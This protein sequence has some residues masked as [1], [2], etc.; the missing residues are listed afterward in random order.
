MAVCIPSSS[1]N[2][3]LR[4]AQTALTD[5][6][7]RV[8][9]LLSS[10]QGAV[11]SQHL[12]PYNCP[13]AHFPFPVNGRWS[14]LGSEQLPV[15]SGLQR[16]LSAEGSSEYATADC[17]SLGGM[18]IPSGSVP[19]G[20]MAGATAAAADATPESRRHILRDAFLQADLFICV[21]VPPKFSLDSHQ[22]FSSTRPGVLWH[23]EQ[24]EAA[25][26]S[27]FEGSDVWGRSLPRQS[28][29]D[30][31]P[32]SEGAVFVPQ[33][34]TAKVIDRT[35]G[36]GWPQAGGAALPQ[37]FVIGKGT[38]LMDNSPGG[39]VDAVFSGAASVTTMQ[40]WPQAHALSLLDHVMV[41]ALRQDG[42]GRPLWLSDPQV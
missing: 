29:G 9:P 15:D 16:R 4:P 31:Q 26:A 19:G 1:P 18:G 30:A 22:P 17:W 8:L 24:V 11:E 32:S 39:D 37:A 20:D 25:G 14:A 13:R 28:L 10:T 40:T 12:G 5:L 38:S 27:T 6:L 41:E 21:H 34:N 23:Q 35:R 33:L 42:M 7:H 2:L 36:G 3:S